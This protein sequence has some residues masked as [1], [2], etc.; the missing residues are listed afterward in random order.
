MDAA[1]YDDARFAHRAQGGGYEVSDRREDDRGVEWGGWR[2]VRAAGP[3]GPEA[4]REAL[5]LR[6]AR[7]G[8]GVDG[9]T[10]PDADLCDD[11][12]RG[13]AR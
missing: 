11:M 1:A 7:P 12:G 6:V 3:Y 5:C 8:E 13:A 10:L 9:A 4:E 2:R